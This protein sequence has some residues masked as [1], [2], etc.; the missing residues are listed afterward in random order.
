MAGR[1]RVPVNIYLEVLRKSKKILGQ[2]CI[3]ANV[4]TEYVPNTSLECY[5]YTILLSCSVVD[6]INSWECTTYDD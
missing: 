4:R 3:S 5:R 2:D 1:L 6:G